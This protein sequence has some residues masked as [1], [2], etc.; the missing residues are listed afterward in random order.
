[1]LEMKLLRSKC[2]LLHGEQWR[3]IIPANDAGRATVMAIVFSLGSPAP[4]AEAI[5]TTLLFSIR[6]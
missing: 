5:E 3:E 4:L 1:M 6:R 2:W